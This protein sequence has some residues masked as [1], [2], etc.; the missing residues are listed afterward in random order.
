[1]NIQYN[2]QLLLSV[3]SF[4]ILLQVYQYLNDIEHCPC[5]MDTNNGHYQTDITFMKFYQFLEMFSLLI[6][7]VLML[8]YGKIQKM[9]GGKKA[10]AKFL[11]TISLS[12]MLFISGYM[13]VNVAKFYFNVKDECKCANKWQKYFLYLEGISNSVYFLRLLFAVLFILFLI[14]SSYSN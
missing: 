11:I 9:S 1:M 2:I 3:V 6:F 10:F 12:I 7:V 8:F 5:F 13:S 14:V 4:V